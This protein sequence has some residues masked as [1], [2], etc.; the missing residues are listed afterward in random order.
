MI[1]VCP[2]T[3]RLAVGSVYANGEIEVRPL[4]SLLVPPPAFRHWGG[5]FETRPCTRLGSQSRRP[6]R[7]RV[8]CQYRPRPPR[9]FLNLKVATGEAIPLS[10]ST[11]IAKH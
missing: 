11:Y 2:L 8:S 9:H 3:F 7:P 10:N 1:T 4:L 6:R 5:G